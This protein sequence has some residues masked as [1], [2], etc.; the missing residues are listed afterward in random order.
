MSGKPTVLEALRALLSVQGYATVAQAVKYTG[1]PYREVVDTL[2]RNRTLYELKGARIVSLNPLSARR[3]EARAAAFAEGKLYRVDEI[4]Y[5][6][7]K[8][9]HVKRDDLVEALGERYTSG[10]LGDSITTTEILA[11]EENVAAV[12][13]AGVRPWGEWRDSDYR[14]WR[15]EH[16][17]GEA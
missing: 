14:Y 13:A 5:G 12:E 16:E 1:R 11:T 7:E 8:A 4:N 3:Q 2:R 17:K 15:E 9:I 10:G 6:A